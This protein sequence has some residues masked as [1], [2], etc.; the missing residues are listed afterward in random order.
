MDANKTDDIALIANTPT[1]TE[2][3]LNGMEQTAGST[4]LNMNADKTV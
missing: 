2:S 3:L 4:G 1:Q